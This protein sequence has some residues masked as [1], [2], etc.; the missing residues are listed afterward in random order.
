LIFDHEIVST[1]IPFL[2]AGDASL[3]YRPAVPFI[4]SVGRITP[5]FPSKEG[6]WSVT[7]V[8]NSFTAKWYR[9]ILHLWEWNGQTVMKIIACQEYD[10]QQSVKEIQRG[11]VKILNRLI[12]GLEW[13]HDP[14]P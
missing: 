8:A 6:S 10:D 1:L 5:Y 12:E 4:T 7:N 11:I 13:S 2:M 14:A 9:P 3:F